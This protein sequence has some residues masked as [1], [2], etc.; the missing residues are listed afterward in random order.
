MGV[1][2]EAVLV[3]WVDEGARIWEVGWVWDCAL[4]GGLKWGEELSG[5]WMCSLSGKGARIGF[6]E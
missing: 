1:V 2:R 4:G 6:G 3:A 5:V